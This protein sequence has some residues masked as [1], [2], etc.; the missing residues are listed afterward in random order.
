[1]VSVTYQIKK[2]Q[3]ITYELTTLRERGLPHNHPCCQIASSLSSRKTLGKGGVSEPPYLDLKTCFAAGNC[4]HTQTSLCKIC[5]TADNLGAFFSIKIAKSLIFMVGGTGI[6]PV[7]S[8][9]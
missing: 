2:H 8:T 6:E 3:E 9:V 4:S 7:T 5:V 1:M